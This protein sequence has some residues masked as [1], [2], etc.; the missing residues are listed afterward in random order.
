MGIKRRRDEREQLRRMVQKWREDV[1][2]FVEIVLGEKPTEQQ[3][4]ILRAV[5]NFPRVAVRSGHSTGKTWT[6][7][8]CALWF[9][10]CFPGSKVLV[11]APTW[12]QIEKVFFAELHSTV[13][14]SILSHLADFTHCTVRMKVRRNRQW[15]PAEYWFIT[16]IASERPENFQGFH[17]R[18]LLCILDEAS[19]VPDSV[20]EAMEGN[21]ATGESKILAI[22]NPLRLSGMFYRIFSE[23]LPNWKTFHLSSLDSPFVSQEWLEEKKKEWGE[24]SNLFRVRVLGE[25]P[26]DEDS[27]LFSF[28]LL[29]E[30]PRWEKNLE[31][32]APCFA[33]VDVARYGECETAVTVVQKVGETFLISEIFSFSH[34]SIPESAERIITMLSPWQVQKV[35]VDDTGVGGG[36][37][38]LLT[39][40]LGSKVQGVHFGSKATKPIFANARA[41]WAYDLKN[42]LIHKRIALLHHVDEHC[43]EK[44][45]Q[46]LGSFRWEFTRTGALRVFSLAQHSDIADSILLAFASAQSSSEHSPKILLLEG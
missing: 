8:R 16:G 22:G 14:R 44:A 17:S 41:E 24:H 37:T 32:S 25:F 29:A 20:W 2:R 6:S 11:T 7:V 12:R 43:W 9:F 21:R 42:S 36:I 3:E 1:V 46:Q 34:S 15:V 26:L 33:G 27:A 28:S 19:G 18:H 13:H 23:N 35:Y 39:Q 45:I 40:S 10:T 4:E 30:V 31:E 5:Q 38:D